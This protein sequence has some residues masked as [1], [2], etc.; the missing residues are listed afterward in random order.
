[1]DKKFRLDVYNIKSDKHKIEGTLVDTSFVS[2]VVFKYGEKSIMI[3][4][5]P[6][7]HHTLPEIGKMAID[8]YVDYLCDMS[9]YVTRM[10]NW[11]VTERYGDK[12]LDGIVT[13][14]KRIQDGH[15]ANAT[16]IQCYKV[17]RIREEIMIQTRNTLY[18]C[19]FAECDWRHQDK[20]PDALPEYA[21]IRKEYRNYMAEHIP[22]IEPG[23]VLLTLSDCDEY[24]FHSL[25]VQKKEGEKP[26]DWCGAANTGRVQDSYC[27]DIYEDEMEAYDISYFPH[28]KNIELYSVCLDDMPLYVENIGYTTLYVQCGGVIELKPGERKEV[29]K[30]NR[31]EEPPYYLPDGD[32]YPCRIGEMLPCADITYHDEANASATEEA[33]KDALSGN[34][35]GPFDSVRDALKDLENE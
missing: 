6:D 1:M 32:L 19:A 20:N 13:G 28:L 25:Y 14:H 33:V 30:E 31:M 4:V 10:H 29:C 23:K 16:D 15:Y 11:V 26:L 5:R 3:A 22:T 9:T 27:I 7:A 21:K 2:K 18:H 24:Y 8:S 17:D 12:Y 35:D 34:T